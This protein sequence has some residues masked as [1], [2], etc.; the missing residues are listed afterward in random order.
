MNEARSLRASANIIAIIAIIITAL[1]GLCSLTVTLNSPRDFLAAFAIGA[2]GYIP[3]GILAYG[4]IR[5]SIIGPNLISE[6]I[7]CIIGAILFTAMLTLGI[8]MLGRQ[9]RWMIALPGA[10]LLL[11]AVWSFV[12]RRKTRHEQS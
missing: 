6:I 4:M 7:A 10:L 8:D 5:H 3:F 11:W 2:V 1:S 12:T 9:G